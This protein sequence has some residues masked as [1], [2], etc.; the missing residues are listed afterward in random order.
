M[1]EATKLDAE[2]VDEPLAGKTSPPVRKKFDRSIVEG[3]LTRAVWKIAWPAVLT[4]LISGV[5]GWVDQ[6]MVG[7][8]IG[9]QANAAIGASFQIFLLVITFIGSIFIGMSV[10]VARFAGAND[11]E[12]VNRSVYQGFLTAAFISLGVLAPIGYFASPFL[13]RLVNAA[14]DVQVEALPFLRIMFT[15]SFGMLIYFMMSGALRSAGDAK[16][17]M[18][19]GIVMTALNLGFNI[20]FIRGLGPIP[21]FGTAGAAIG[22]CLASGIVGVYAI[23]KLYSGTWVVGFP[24]SGYAPDWKVIKKLFSFGLPAG[25]QGIAMNA[26][27]VLMYAFMGGLAQGEATQAVYAVAY[28]QLFLLVTF[29]SNALMGA[30]ASVTGQ[31]LGAGH[32][33]R[34]N[35]APRTAAAFGIAGATFVGLCFFFLPQQLL[36]IFGMTDPAVVGIGVEL[37]RVLAVSGVFIST[38]LAYTGGLQGSGDTRSPLYISIVSQVIVPLSICFIIKNVWHLA[39][40]HIWIAILA[41]HVTR[42]ALSVGR[43]LQ[44]KWRTIAVDIETTQA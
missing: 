10:L 13:L 6:I 24:R 22:T 36:S 5:Q 30:S 20:V 34:A 44:G 1:T 15:C 26:G 29:S 40:I 19:L 38:A 17:P 32:A 23:Y 9:Y 14:P 21:A 8:L 28:G 11:H 12:K 2:A 27:G 18:V 42:A 7:N 31:N 35:A 4:N 37:L 16:T 25:I 3:P 39:P 43:F 41:G 33:E